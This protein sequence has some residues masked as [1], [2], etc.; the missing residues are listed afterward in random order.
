MQEEAL[1]AN[2]PAWWPLTRCLPVLQD[3]PRSWC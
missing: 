2:C 1:V 3:G